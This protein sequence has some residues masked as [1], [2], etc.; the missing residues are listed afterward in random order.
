MEESVSVDTIQITEN[1]SDPTANS[2]FDNSKDLLE[3]SERHQVVF[4]QRVLVLSEVLLLS[5][6]VSTVYLIQIHTKKIAD[7]LQ[8]D[9][10][11]YAWS[12]WEK[13]KSDD[14]FWGSSMFIREAEN[15]VLFVRF[16]IS[17]K[18]Y[19]TKAGITRYKHHHVLT[20][21]LWIPLIVF[22]VLCLIV[23]GIAHTRTKV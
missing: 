13:V 4:Y 3:S 18:R 15:R 2:G 16:Q 17:Q 23:M 21:V 22:C 10:S 6:I 14:K 8:K 9:T 20:E 12:D 5:A 1:R 19:P 7:S 11:A